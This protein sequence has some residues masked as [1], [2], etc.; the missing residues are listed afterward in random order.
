MAAPPEPTQRGEASTGGKGLVRLATRP[1]RDRS[2]VGRGGT[3]GDFPVIISRAGPLTE[4]PHDNVPHTFARRPLAS[5]H[6]L[7]HA[8]QAEKGEEMRRRVDEVMVKSSVHDVN[9]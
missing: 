3:R 5:P 6:L 8:P 4:R 2:G 9:L 7:Y 1:C